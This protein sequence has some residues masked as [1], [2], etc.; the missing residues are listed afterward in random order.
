MRRFARSVLAAG[1]VALPARTLADPIQLRADALA[2]TAAPAGLVTLEATAA[3]SPGWSAEAVVWT[4]S[5]GD[6]GHTDVLVMAV[7]AHTADGLAGF[8]L[9]RF[10]ESLGALQP[11]QIDGAAGRLRLPL[12]LDVEAYAGVP[13]ESGLTTPR[14]WS[15]AAGGRIAQRIGDGGS[16]GVAYAE[17]RADGRLA[18]EEVGLD[19]GAALGAHDDL[20]ARLAYDLANPGLA[21][22]GVTAS[23]RA[24]RWRTSLYLEQRAAAHL[25]PATSLF[26]VLGDV[27]AT[28]AGAV[29]T[30]RAAPRLDVIADLGVQ[31]VDRDVAPQLALR[32]QLRL[33]EL[34]TS[35]LSGELRRDGVGTDTWTGARGAARIALP[36][37][38]A[39]TSELEL[40]VPDHA[41]GQGAMWPWGLVALAWERAGWQAAIAIEASASPEDRHRVDVLGQLGRRW[42]MP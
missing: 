34:G 11:R 9:G 10:V 25:L 30:W 16:I 27:P 15:W 24:K 42:G 2:S 4:G 31:R 6:Q 32:G 3:A 1:V 37:A 18:S 33:D 26:S 41:H 23:H 5:A 8:R 17:Q 22:L 39:V 28:R 38:L 36:C 40:V 20:G 13:V 7:R 35:T 29:T 14:A 19:A 21:E 12:R